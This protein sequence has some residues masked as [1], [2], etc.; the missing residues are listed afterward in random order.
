M[1]TWTPGLQVQ[2]GVRME[3]GGGGRG[4]GSKSVLWVTD[5][6]L[7]PDCHKLVVGTTSQELSFYDTTT[8]SYRCQYRIQGSPALSSL[9]VREDITHTN[10]FSLVDLPSVPL[11]IAYHCSSEVCTTLQ[12][13]PCIRDTHCRCLMLCTLLPSPPPTSY[14][15]TSRV[16]WWS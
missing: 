8:P 15:V 10:H 11:C 4:R 3:E 5:C 2:H 14:M 9:R 7:L 1:S 12:I 6:T 13:C 16:Q